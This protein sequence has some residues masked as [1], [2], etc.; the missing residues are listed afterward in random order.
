M[1]GRP[2]CRHH[3]AKG[4]GSGWMDELMM[5]KKGLMTTFATWVLVIVS[6]LLN[7]IWVKFLKLAWLL[8][9]SVSLLLGESLL[10]PPVTLKP[11]SHPSASSSLSFHSSIPSLPSSSFPH[12][13]SQPL[14]ATIWHQQEDSKKVCVWQVWLFRLPVFTWDKTVAVTTFWG[15]CLESLHPFN[16]DV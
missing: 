15:G 12:S 3:G 11:N 5:N 14:E 1:N 9:P 10:P 13:P 16:L 6:A 2:S 8:K 4:T 7:V